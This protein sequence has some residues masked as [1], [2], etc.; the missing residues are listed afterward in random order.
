M[1]SRVTTISLDED[2]EKIKKRI[3]NFSKFVRECL[4]RWDAVQRD[5]V[6]RTERAFPESIIG[7]HCIPAPNRVCLKHWPNGNAN[8]QD[9]REFRQM[10]D[11]EEQ[12]HDFKTSLTWPFLSE[13]DFN[14]RYWIQHRA[15]MVNMPMIE[16][17]GIELEGNAKP[18][19]DKR[20]RKKRS[21][22]AKLLPFLAPKQG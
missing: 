17:D 12:G 10:I 6:C 15:E 14:P 3:P 7:D 13:F 4:L 8:M 2:T 1:S 5:P 9:W 22:M 20:R 21:L 11:A 18:E 16:F 19:N